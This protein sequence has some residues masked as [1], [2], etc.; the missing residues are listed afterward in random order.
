MDFDALKGE[1]LD[2]IALRLRATRGAL[3][4]KQ[5]S[6]CTQAGIAANTYNQWEMAKIRPSLDGAILLCRTYAL[7]LDWIYRGDPSGLPQR[8]VAQLTRQAVA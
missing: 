3:G 5:S 6:F 1:D 4:L 8:P 7:T 2:A